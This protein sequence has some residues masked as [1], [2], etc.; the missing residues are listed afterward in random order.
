MTNVSRIRRRRTR[1][2][3]WIVRARTRWNS[4]LCS[5]HCAVD[6]MQEVRTELESSGGPSRGADGQSMACTSSNDGRE[7]YCTTS[8]A[9]WPYLGVWRANL[10]SLLLYCAA[11]EQDCSHDLACTGINSIDDALDEGSVTNARCKIPPHLH[12]RDGPAA[13]SES[14]LH[15]ATRR[16]DRLRRCNGRSGDQ[17]LVVFSSMQARNN[18][19]L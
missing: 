4:A 8:R 12:D 3:S 1:H 14:G 15:T 2:A 16:L 18:F 19:P 7:C 17:S 11:I 5:T 10:R 9:G 6:A 13:A